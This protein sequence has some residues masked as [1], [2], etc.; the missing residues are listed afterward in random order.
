MEIELKEHNIGFF[1]KAINVGPNPKAFNVLIMY[2]QVKLSKALSRSNDKSRISLGEE[3]SQLVLTAEINAKRP[4]DLI[5]C[6][7][8]HV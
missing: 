6:F 2:F 8:F 7:G 3:V 5:Q 4:M 1:S